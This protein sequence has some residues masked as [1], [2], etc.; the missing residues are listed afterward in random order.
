MTKG[1]ANYAVARSVNRG[2]Y[3]CAM[4]FWLESGRLD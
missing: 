1:V 3:R 2:K 4:L